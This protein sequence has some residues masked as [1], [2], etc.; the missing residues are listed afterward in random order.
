[1]CVLAH[2]LQKMKTSRPTIIELDDFGPRGSQTSGNN[3]KTKHNANEDSCI[4]G[5]PTEVE[6]LDD[7]FSDFRLPEQ[8][9]VQ[10]ILLK[11]SLPYFFSALIC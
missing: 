5:C 8:L 4:K 6:N 3:A 2:A 10:C 7:F 11:S 9:K 1:M